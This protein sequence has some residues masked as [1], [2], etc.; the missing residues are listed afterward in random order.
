MVDVSGGYQIS[1]SG[2]VTGGDAGSL[3]LQGYALVVDGD[4][5]AQ[6]LLGNNGGAITMTAGSIDIAAAPA[7]LPGG[8][9]A[10]SPLP[11][12]PE[13]ETGARVRPTRRDG[14]YLHHP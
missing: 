7:S 6:S 13:G 2:K 10:A 1:P 14:L 3:T 9:T 5:R 11:A 8:F 4:L 12:E